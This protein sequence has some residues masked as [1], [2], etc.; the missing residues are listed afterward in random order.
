MKHVRDIS[1][2]YLIPGETQ[3]TAL[4]FVPSKS[5]YAEIHD[6]FDDVIQKAYRARVVMVSPSLLMLAIQVMQQIMKD[7]KM[8]EAAYTIRK[9]VLN[10]GDDLGRLRDRVL[11]LQNHFSRGERGR[12]P[13]PDLRRQDR[14]TSRADRGTRFQQDRNTRWNCRAS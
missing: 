10:L 12:P 6:G 9:E 1:E 2:Q 7:A 14:K 3:D 11:K 13:D 5:V 4:M 8:R